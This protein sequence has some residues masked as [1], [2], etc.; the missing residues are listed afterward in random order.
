M[1]RQH[2]RVHIDLLVERHRVQQRVRMPLLLSQQDVLDRLIQV[3]GVL[4]LPRVTL[5]VLQELRLSVSAFKLTAA[6]RSRI[7]RPAISASM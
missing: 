7:A 5:L 6:A 2:L 3:V 1:R 4:N